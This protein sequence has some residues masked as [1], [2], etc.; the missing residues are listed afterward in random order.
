MDNIIELLKARGLLEAVTHD[1]ITDHL[2][3]PRKIYCGFDPTAESLHLGNLV[4]IIVLAWFQKLG[5]T[6]YAIVGGATGMIG[7][8][9]GKSHE[10][11]LLDEVTIRRNLAG[12]QKNLQT[13]LSFEGSL[14]Q[15]VVLNNHDWFEGFGLLPFLRD[16]GKKFR[17]GPMLSKESVKTRLESEEG[18]SF[19]EFTYQ[20]LQG[21]DFYHLFS[22]HGVSVQCG[23]SDQWGNIVAGIDLTRRETARQV[24]GITFPLLTR[25]DGKKF[26]KSEN[27]AIWLSPDRL[28]SYD[29]YQ[30]LVRIPDAD[31]IRLMKMITF[32]DLEEIGRIEKSMSEQGYIPNTAQRR[33]AEEVTRMI[34]GEAGLQ[35]ALRITEGMSPGAETSLDRQTLEALA[36][37]MPT[38]SG[39]LDDYLE[40]KLVDCIV[41]LGIRSSKGEVR[42]L[43]R[44]GGVYLNNKKVAE[45]EQTLQEE[46]LIDGELLLLA[47][48]KKNKYL[49]RLNGRA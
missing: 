14:P 46:D 48:G 5:H 40:R 20:L 22:K 28:S 19:T 24:Y 27:G 7:D 49:V 11:P 29:F 41:N 12:I 33:L 38:F 15:P 9:S 13:V 37:E 39:S 3:T 4:P 2:K 26:G 36:K 47:I 18:M 23:G 31:V 6:P 32:M 10:R 21:Y 1:E 25:S 45:E 42:R 8:P 30:Y 43:I 44:G 17:M 35:Q 34:H 16:I